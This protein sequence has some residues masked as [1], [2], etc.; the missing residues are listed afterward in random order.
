MGHHPIGIGL[1]GAGRHGIRYARHIVQDLPGARLA[2]VCRQHPEQLLDVPGT[3][4]VMMYGEP[5]ALIHDPSVDVVIIVTPPVL[6]CDICLESIRA[7][8]P[9]LV[10]KPLSVSAIDAKRMVDAARKTGVPLMTGQTL[11][12]DA[13]IQALKDKRALI[14]HPQR[15]VLT[16]HIETKITKPDHAVGYGQRGALLEIGIHLL[17]LVRFLTGEEVGEVECMMDAVPPAAPETSVTAHLRTQNGID[18]ALDV[19][20]VAAGRRGT[21]VCVGSDG[22]ITADWIEQRVQF[23]R[24]DQAETWTTSPSTTVLSTVTAFLHAV[25]WKQHMPITGEDGFRAVEIADAC[26]HSASTGGRPVIL[27]LV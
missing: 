16:S 20:R 4:S 12:F 18:C 25:E 3:E 10:E 9:V 23:T 13:T 11:R 7:G 6:S 19:R 24:G 1:I 5:A 17:D 14:G 26:Y 15:M 2:A 21:A 27:P 22:Q 8:K